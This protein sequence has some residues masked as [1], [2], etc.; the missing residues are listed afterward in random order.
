MDW[1]SALLKNIG[2]LLLTKTNGILRGVLCY[3]GEACISGFEH[4]T[5]LYEYKSCFRLLFFCFVRLFGSL[6]FCASLW[7]IRYEVTLS[8]NYSV[9]NRELGGSRVIVA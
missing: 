6:G 4:R 8:S 1:W 7:K 9:I 5:R 2:I 3:D